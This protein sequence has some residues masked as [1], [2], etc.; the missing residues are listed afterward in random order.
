MDNRLKIYGLQTLRSGSRGVPNKNTMKIK[1]VPLYMYNLQHMK[2][3]EI[4]K[5]YISTDYEHIIDDTDG[6]D[7][8]VIKRPPELCNDQASHLEVLQHSI[9]EIESREQEQ[10]DIL[11]VVFGNS[12]SAY[13]QDLNGAIGFLKE[14]PDFDSVQSVSRLD[15]Y[16]PL[17]ASRLEADGTLTSVLNEDAKKLLMKPGIPPGDRDSAGSCYFFNG[18]FW[19]CQRDVILNADK[20]SVYPW[21]GKTIRGWVQ[22]FCFDIDESWQIPLLQ[23]LLGDE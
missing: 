14:N 22:D 1:G 5:I 12:I 8:K 6:H 21:L 17:R 3:S 10:V 11:A 20:S 15:M 23:A 19:I 13:P 9:R 4:E 18:S 7:C 16:N 2:T